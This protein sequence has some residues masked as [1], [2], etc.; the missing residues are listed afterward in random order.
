MRNMTPEMCLQMEPTLDKSSDRRYWSSQCEEDEQK[1]RTQSCQNPSAFPQN[2][3]LK[4]KKH[5]L[6]SQVYMNESTAVSNMLTTNVYP[7][8][9]H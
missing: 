5:K 8:S 4:K 2:V 1:I 7:T 9:L 3:N 6:H